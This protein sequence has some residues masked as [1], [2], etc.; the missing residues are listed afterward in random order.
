MQCS[1]DHWG[2]LERKKPAEAG[3]FQRTGEAYF[4]FAAALRAGLR[5]G[6]FV[7]TGFFAEAFLAFAGDFLAA[8]FLAGAFFAT[9]LDAAAFFALGAAFFA[10][11]FFAGL[12]AFF[13]VF[14][15]GMVRDLRQTY[16]ALRCEVQHAP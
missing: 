12:A 6:A 5:A 13:A 16:C 2:V 4:F 1:F 7:A 8:A 3:F 11:A 14:F 15:T 10:A 9:G